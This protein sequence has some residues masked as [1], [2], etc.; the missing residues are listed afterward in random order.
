M[1][2]TPSNP[3]MRALTWIAIAGLVLGVIFLFFGPT[4]FFVGVGLIGFA[5]SAAL[6]RLGAQAARWQPPSH[7]D[8]PSLADVR[9]SRPTNG[10]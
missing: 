2:E 3:F 1:D 10:E 4:L 5:L 8:R 9:S 6:I 7:P